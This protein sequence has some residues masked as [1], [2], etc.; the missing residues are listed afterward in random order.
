MQEILIGSNEA[1]QRLDKF[2][3]KCLPS[4]GNAFLYKMLRKKNITLNGSRAEGREQLRQGDVV[5]MFFA[6]ETFQKFSAS[7]DGE[8]RLDS[9]R[10]AY[11]QLEG[12]HVLYEDEDRVVLNKPAGILTQKAADTDLSL[13]EWLIGYLLESGGITLE[14]LRT[15]KPSV[16]NRLDRNTS[17]LVLC[18]K[19][20]S[21]TQA[22]S[23]ALRTRSISKYYR[24]VCVGELR[25]EL[26]LDGYLRKDARANK[27]EI[28]ARNHGGT[29]GRIAGR[30]VG[31]IDG[32]LADG[33]SK[34]ENRAVLTICRPLAAASGYTLLEV[35]LV[36]G[37]T[38]QI[39]AHLAGI[40][41]P[42]AG[43]YK[44]GDQKVNDMLKARYG[45]SHQLLHAYRVV[46][47]EGRE[48]TAPYPAL[49][50]AVAEGM[51]LSDGLSR[52]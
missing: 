49:F 31:R 51:G 42:L 29:D 41:H 46:W 44:Y 15:F 28:Q 50:E 47:S 34:E 27:V 24:A 18:G 21:G 17:G 7:L 40:G 12:I 38:H 10:R 6:E 11:R 20:L 33:S 37:K 43:D 19:T 2:L 48:I 9:F 32:N 5:R 35:E 3:R 13:N 52:K 4:A 26:R 23:E 1:G 25:Q 36:T 45:L 22:L 30:I 14:M 39:R 16:C 8:E